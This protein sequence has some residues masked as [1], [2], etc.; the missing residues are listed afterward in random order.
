MAVLGAPIHRTISFFGHMLYSFCSDFRFTKNSPIAWTG[1]P[2]RPEGELE[3]MPV[4][5]AGKSWQDKIEEA[6]AEIKK[7]GC[8]GLIITMLD[9]VAWLFNL[10]GTDIPFNPLF[11]SYC[12]VGSNTVKLFMNQKQATSDVRAHLEGVEIC[13]YGDTR[14]FLER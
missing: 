14:S 1:R 7:A 9:E 2:D 3:I 8:E 13:N 10:R 12:Y 5:T 6:R 11:F 4:S